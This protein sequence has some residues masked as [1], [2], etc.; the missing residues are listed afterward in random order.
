[1]EGRGWVKNMGREWGQTKVGRIIMLLNL[2]CDRYE[3][4]LYYINKIIF[5]TS[6][7]VELLMSYLTT[8]C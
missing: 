3:N 1:M 4:S 5:K 6:F 2:Y 7:F 8:Y